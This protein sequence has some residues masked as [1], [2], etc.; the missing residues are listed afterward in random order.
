MSDKLHIFNEDLAKKIT[1]TSRDAIM[2]VIKNQKPNMVD[3][4]PEYDDED[5][6]LNKFHISNEDV[7]MMRLRD[8]VNGRVDNIN[9]KVGDYIKLI[10][11]S[12]YPQ[13]QMSDTAM[14][15][16]TNQ[17]FIE[18]AKGDVLIGGLGIGM[19]IIAIV[20]KP[21]V[22]SI[23]VIESNKKVAEKIG[24][25]LEPHFNKKVT[26]IHADV[27]EWQPEQN[28]DTIYMDVWPSI[29]GDNWS[30]MVLLGRDYRPYLNDGGWFGCWRE[31]DCKRLSNEICSICN[32]HI[33]DC[34]CDICD[35][36]G[37]KIDESYCHDGRILC[38]D[39]WDFLDWKEIDNYNDGVDDD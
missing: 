32:E 35:E 34:M 26:I 36:C 1:K 25:L 5:I 38:V 37:E 22:K 3:Y 21:E 15:W 16:D 23:T 10:T 17:E 11:K 9:L 24:E 33:D 13:L 20:N 30:D 6:T 29:C 27:Y 18:Y 28:Y 7:Q 19:I 39:C 8:A 14:E 2:K 4:L 31:D 12:P